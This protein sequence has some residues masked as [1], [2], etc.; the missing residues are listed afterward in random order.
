MAVGDP[1]DGVQPN[2]TKFHATYYGTIIL[3]YNMVVILHELGHDVPGVDVQDARGK[4]LEASEGLV[5]IAD[6]ALTQWNDPTLQPHAM[7]LV[8][9]S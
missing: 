8:R 2:L 3:L 1:P 6:L 7:L 9:C 5:G 4:T